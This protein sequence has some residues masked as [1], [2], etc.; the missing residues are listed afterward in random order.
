[1]FLNMKREE[2]CFVKFFNLVLMEPEQQREHS[3]NELASPGSEG[4]ASD[5]T[6]H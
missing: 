2:S 4:R 6:A 1:M 5:A 3:V